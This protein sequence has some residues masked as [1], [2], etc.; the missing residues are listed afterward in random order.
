MKILNS[1]G[2]YELPQ[3]D[4]P[5]ETIRLVINS[6]DGI[7]GTVLRCANILSGQLL[8]ETTLSES[9]YG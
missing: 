1:R 8:Q 5:I 2:F 7:N 4:T 3:I 6:K 9:V